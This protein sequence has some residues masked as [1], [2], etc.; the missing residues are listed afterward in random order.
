MLAV[1]VLYYVRRGKDPLYNTYVTKASALAT[2]GLASQFSGSALTTGLAIEMVVLLISS[3]R[4]G[5]VI[6]RILAHVVAIITFAHGVF[7][8]LE[9]M[10]FVPYRDEAYLPTLIRALIPLIAFAVASQ[11]YERTDWST[12]MRLGLGIPNALRTLFWQLDLR[13]LDELD[14]GEVEKPFRGLFFPY[15]FSLAAAFLFL[16]YSLRLID[17]D[18][19]FNL[20]GLVGFGALLLAWIL[21]TR[22]FAVSSV[23]YLGLAIV[24]S[25]HTLMDDYMAV[26]FGAGVL[27][28]G[29][30]ALVTEDK[31]VPY[32][33]S[34]WL[35]RLPIAPYLMYGGIFWLI[36]AYA[37]YFFEDQ[38]FVSALLALCIVT[39][40]TTVKL[41]TKAVTFVA[42]A[43]LFCA[44]MIWHINVLDLGGILSNYDDQ[45]AWSRSNFIALVMLTCLADRFTHRLRLS[46]YS[47]VYFFIV[48]T[49]SMHFIWIEAPA[50]WYGAFQAVVAF[51]Y[52]GYGFAFWSKAAG[53]FAV[54]TAVVASLM[55]TA[56]AYDS[57][58]SLVL[59]T[60]VGFVSVIALW[61][62]F[63]RANSKLSVLRSTSAQPVIAG[64]TISVTTLLALI[65]LERIPQLSDLY[66]TVS[67]SLL[68]VVFFA[69]ALVSTQKRYRYAG[70]AILSLA[71]FRVVVY[72]TSALDATNRVLAYGGL[73]VVLLGLGFG[74]SKAFGK[75]DRAVEETAQEADTEGK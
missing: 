10:D 44:H 39:V 65:T 21:N 28:F 52:L 6:T 75:E 35:Y 57:N 54:L 13:N 63:E 7:T 40:A 42:T 59:P 66:L 41:H 31:F 4:S 23:F 58:S 11:L 47:P 34:I 17:I 73:G 68:A 3:R 19:R 14:S 29:L 25:I 36:V 50:E 51:G 69:V 61:I 16:G 70:L 55:Q 9:L 56:W 1:G 33:D 67:W 2:L 72:D 12:R 37:G 27:F 5:L 8:F 45:L 38:H 30:S 26:S 32:R 53:G 46:F 20:Y 18:D 43:G 64:I 71:T 49:S 60:V 74:Y 62:L 15:A 48:F 24:A 22:A